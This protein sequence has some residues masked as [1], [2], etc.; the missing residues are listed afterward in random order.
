MAGRSI[1]TYVDDDDDGVPLAPPMRPEAVKT[2]P[3][4]VEEPPEEGDGDGE[5]PQGEAVGLPAQRIDTS[6]SIP[7]ADGTLLA[8]EGERE[9]QRL[10]EFLATLEPAPPFWARWLDSAGLRWA[11]VLLGSALTLFVIAQA[12]LFVSQVSALPEPARTIA[13]VGGGIVVLAFVIA[14][15]R[16]ILLYVRLQTTPAF[17]TDALYE[18]SARQLT[19][20]AHARHAYEV[21]YDRLRPI[22]A[23]YPLGTAPFERK[24]VLC[25][26][27]A[28]EVARLTKMRENLLRANQTKADWVR[29]FDRHFLGLLD[30]VAARRIR[31]AALS[32]GKLTAVSPRGSVDAVIVTALAVELVGDLCAVYNVRANRVDTVRIVGTVLLNTAAASQADDLTQ[33]GAHHLFDALQGHASWLTALFGKAAQKVTG[34]VA[35]GVVNGSLMYRLGRLTARALRPLQ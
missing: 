22:L 20:A 24:L 31:R 5:V 4:I 32:A 29:E 21:V 18:L 9:Q 14:G 6:N 16:L 17:Q 12:S 30:E 25:G 34:G 27:T 11:A 19:R 13:L 15:V 8:R 7:L 23:T 26:A 3:V 33:E 10:E 1:P 2:P 28:D 35:D